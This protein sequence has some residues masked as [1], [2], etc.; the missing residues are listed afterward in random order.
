MENLL[1]DLMFDLS[2]M[3]GLEEVVINEEVV[4]GKAEPLLVYA[5]EKE[6]NAS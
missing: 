2:S 3:H 5:K 1:L 4:E 6:K